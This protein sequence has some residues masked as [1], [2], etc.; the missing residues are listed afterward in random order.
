MRIKS[1]TAGFSLLEMLIV[2]VIVAILAAIALSYYQ[3]AVQ[4]ARST[5]AVIWWGQSKQWMSGRNITRERANKI[6]QD[7]NEKQQLKYFTLKLVCRPKENNQLCW[8]AEFYLKVPNQQVQ[9]YLA[10]QKNFL[11]LTCVP[12]NSAGESFC[13]SQSGSNDG[14]NAEINE[15][16]AYLIR[17]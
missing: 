16:P 15:Q 17:Y 7:V 3:N 9:Y 6:E 4:S 8:E 10:T 5:E 14:P 13:Q 1:Y 11:Q 2:V 12:Q